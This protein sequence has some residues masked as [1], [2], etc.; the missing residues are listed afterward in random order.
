MLDEEIRKEMRT[1]IMNVIGG[2]N[3]FQHLGFDHK[4]KIRGF[5]SIHFCYFHD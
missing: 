1:R 4:I 2:F 5:N 3:D